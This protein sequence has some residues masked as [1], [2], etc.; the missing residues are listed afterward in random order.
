MDHSHF[1]VFHYLSS[2]IFSL[3]HNVYL[4]RPNLQTNVV[5][6]LKTLERKPWFSLNCRA[7]QCI[8]VF[9]A[10]FYAKLFPYTAHACMHAYLHTWYI[11]VFSFLP[12]LYESTV[13]ASMILLLDSNNVILLQQYTCTQHWI[14]AFLL[15]SC[16]WMVAETAK[17]F[18]YTIPHSINFI[19]GIR[20][21][22]TSKFVTW[23]P[24]IAIN[25]QN[26]C[27][28]YSYENFK[29]H[30]LAKAKVFQ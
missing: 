8:V 18:Y 13:Y 28:F 11:S 25:K 15:F 23:C 10:I 29:F 6:N 12:L 4:C 27:K 24:M 19:Y 7:R 5:Y 2:L 17:R 14:F 1:I 16:S 26:S 21:L 9:Q 30:V 20:N 22:M 3:L